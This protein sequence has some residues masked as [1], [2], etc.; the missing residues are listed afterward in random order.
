[1][2]LV[3][4]TQLKPQTFILLSLYIDVAIHSEQ[5]AT[6]LLKLTLFALS[7]ISHAPRT[8]TEL[9]DDSTLLTHTPKTE[10]GIRNIK[11]SSEC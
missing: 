10:P 8:P 4:K 3:L 5:Q 11:L 9:R 2:T 7:L 1:M 6:L